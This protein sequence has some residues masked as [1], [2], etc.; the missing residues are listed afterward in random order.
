ML[1]VLAID[2]E[3][4]A[5]RQLVS[6]IQRVPFLQL[7]A[8]CQS[9]IEAQAYVQ[10]GGIDAIFCDINMPDLN[11]MN[12]AR[13]L[14]TQAATAPL[15]VFTT[16]YSE[17]AVEGFRVDA[18]DYLLKPF[19]FD[20][21][22]LSS[23]RLLK[24]HELIQQAAANTHLAADNAPTDMLFVRADRATQAIPLSSIRYVQ[25]MSEYLRFFTSDRPRPITTLLTMKSLEER[26][27]ADRFLR[28][29]RSYIVALAEIRQ[30]TRSRVILTDG[31]ELPVG[32]NSRAALEAWLNGHSEPAR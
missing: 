17:Y 14:D 23:E 29:H 9:A 16:A 21:F 20:E 31:T 12:F 30:V 15:V 28:I 13:A 19:S 8:Q 27:P 5:L 22:Q 25:G 24:R 3:P 1:R 10:R 32:D 7:V 6:Y 26:L 11:G 2:D 18:V 4:L